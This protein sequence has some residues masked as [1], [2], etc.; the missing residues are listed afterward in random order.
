MTGLYVAALLIGIVAGLR[1][2]TPL[3]VLSWAA[4]AKCLLLEGTWASF[5]ASLVVAIIAT[6]LAAGEIVNDKLPKTPSRKAPPAFAA[7][8]VLGA[9]YGAVFG[10]LAHDTSSGLFI[11]LVLGAIG[12][13]IGTLGGAWV[14]E[15]LASAFGKDLPAALIEDAITIAAALAITAGLAA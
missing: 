13:V 2:M 7:R 3:A 9:F 15:A 8:V 1:A 11:G 5:L 12:A 4:F 14:R 10:T 6:V